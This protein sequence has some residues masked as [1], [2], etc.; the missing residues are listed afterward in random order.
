[1]DFNKLTIKS[2]EAVAGAQELARRA[3]NPEL[4]RDHLLVALLEQELP[5]TLLQRA[6]A[7]PEGVVRCSHADLFLRDEAL[8]AL[9]PDFVL[10]LG[11][12]PT[13]KTLATWLARHRPPLRLRCRAAAA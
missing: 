12:I 3:G 5:R 6:G 8:A 13:S 1:M 11:G 2:G 7:D 9:A 10:R 4:T